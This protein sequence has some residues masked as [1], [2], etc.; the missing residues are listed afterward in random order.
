MF[1]AEFKIRSSSILL[2]DAIVIFPEVVLISTVSTNAAVFIAPRD[3]F[4][5]EVI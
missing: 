3:K 1:P 2:T 4:A 5:P